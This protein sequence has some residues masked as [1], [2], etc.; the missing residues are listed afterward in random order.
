MKKTSIAFVLAFCS[1]C[2]EGSSDSTNSTLTGIFVPV[3]T[4]DNMSTTSDDIFPT[5]EDPVITTEIPQDLPKESVCGNN[6]VEGSEEC[7]NNSDSCNNCYLDRLVFVTSDTYLALQLTFSEYICEEVPKMAGISGEFVPIL[8]FDEN[9]VWNSIPASE[10]RYILTDGSVF[11]ESFSDLIEGKIKN[12][13]AYN[14]KGKQGSAY[15]WTGAGPENCQSWSS[16]AGYG[17]IGYNNNIS[18]WLNIKEMELVENPSPCDLSRAI[19]CIQI[20]I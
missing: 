2:P 11:A 20:G 5:S 8:R 12:P 19:Y 9:I 18:D 4:A 17:I 10:G 14:E 13:P 6:I 7:D 1:A 15:V 16:S 3:T